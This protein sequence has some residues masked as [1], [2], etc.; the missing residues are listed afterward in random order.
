MLSSTKC[1]A[2]SI[3]LQGQHSSFNHL[4]WSILYAWSYDRIICSL[5]VRS[6]GSLESILLLI[7]L[8]FTNLIVWGQVI[9]HVYSPLLLYFISLRF[10][11]LFYSHTSHVTVDNSTF[12]SC[13]YLLIGGTV[14]SLQVLILSF[15]LF[16]M[17]F[18]IMIIHDWK[19]AW[20]FWGS[21]KK[22]NHKYRRLVI[23]SF[24]SLYI[25]IFG[26]LFFL[27]WFLLRLFT[28]LFLFLQKRILYTLL[29]FE[30]KESR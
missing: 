19:P 29:F 13:H 2:L 12:S 28:M 24:N 5:A 1:L 18:V 25:L 26:L 22:L 23:L 8:T 15:R 10:N 30:I 11:R 20:N 14:F 21:Q 3:C 17:S 4:Y 9:N 6:L 16:T 27:L 7:Y